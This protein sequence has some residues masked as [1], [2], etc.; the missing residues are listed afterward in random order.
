MQYKDKYKYKLTWHSYSDHLRKTLQEM[1]TSNAFAD[2]TLVT[3]D[4]QQIMAHQSILSACSSVFKN[5]LQ[6]DSSNTNPIIYLRGIQYSEMESIMQFIY[7][8]EARFD[9]DRIGEFLMVSK[10]LEIKGLSTDLEKNEQTSSKK[11]SMEDEYDFTEDDVDDDPSQTLNEDVANGTTDGGKYACKQCDKQFTTQS[12][13][14]SHIQSK[15]EGVKYACDQCAYEATHQSNLKS[16]IQS[17]HEGVKYACDQCDKQFTKQDKLKDHTQATHDGIK[18]ACNQCDSE[19]KHQRSLKTH[20]QSLHE[21]V[22][23]ACAQCPYQA[24]QHSILRRHVRSKHE[25]VKFS[26]KQCD[27]Q[28]ARQDYLT[29]HI[30]FKHA[31]S[32]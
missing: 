29:V 22:N 16:H 24:T 6:L 25:G 32:R 15:H 17:V 8:G 11:E 2:V 12:I 3:D 10:N 28:F 5:I 13:L 4:K 30:Q 19:F 31:C 27:Q 20:I 1:M 26:C 21:G 9:E 23:Y 18:Y 14:K 7:L